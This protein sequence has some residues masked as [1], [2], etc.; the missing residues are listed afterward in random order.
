VS[1]QVSFEE[2]WNYVVA[3]VTSWRISE[4]D[5]DTCDIPVLDYC[6]VSGNRPVWYV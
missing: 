4:L 3:R 1:V 2:R 5:R 6:S